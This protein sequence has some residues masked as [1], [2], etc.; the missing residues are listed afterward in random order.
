MNPERCDRR[1]LPDPT[2][3]A[4]APSRL[5]IAHMYTRADAITDRLLIEV[6]PSLIRL[7]RLPW[8]VAVTRRRGPM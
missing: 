2:T 3:N 1:I 4:A 5:T 8:P 6:P 7:H